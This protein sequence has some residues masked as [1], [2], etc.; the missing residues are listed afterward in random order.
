MLLPLDGQRLLILSLQIRRSL[1]QL[2]RPGG[3]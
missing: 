2:L 3:G 1:R